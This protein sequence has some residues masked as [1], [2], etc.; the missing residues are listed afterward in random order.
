MARRLKRPTRLQTALLFSLLVHAALLAVRFADPEGF[1]RLM[2][3]TP[4]EVVLVNARADETPPA[5]PQA[6]AQASLAGGG[7]AE[8]GRATSP[9]PL[10]AIVS[11]GD[12][13]QQAT[14]QIDRMQDL[15]QQLLTQVRRELAMLQ[16]PDPA[17]D[18][19]PD[20]QR[21]REERRQRMLRMLAEIEKR[22]NDE[23]ARPKRR[24]ISPATREEIY[25][26]YYDALRRKIEDRGTRD[27]P[28]VNGQKLYGELTMNVTIDAEGRVV[29]AEV[30]RSSRNKALD[31][32]AVAIVHASAPF[33]LFSTAMR[34]GADQ[35]VVTSRFRFTR[36]EG[37]ETSL[38]A[39]TP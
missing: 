33:G 38:S 15:Q 31:K 17:R 2:T 21:D 23:N 13:T 39:P 25:A 32:R 18:E 19:T 27:F 10:A 1:N 36:D 26:V 7:D 37:L 24:Y 20:A 28:E 9:L 35:I 6:I 29:E 8:R 16:A 30:V 5:K 34:R 11:E 4:L 3:D 22:V 12:D 14:R